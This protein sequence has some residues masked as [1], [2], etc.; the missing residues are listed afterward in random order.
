[1]LTTQPARSAQ[2]GAGGGADRSAR[3]QRI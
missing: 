2:C 3:F 1:L